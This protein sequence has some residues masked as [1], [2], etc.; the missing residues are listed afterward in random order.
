MLIDWFTVAAQAVNFLVLIWLLKRFLY[1][2]ILSAIDAR[3]KALAARQAD[4]ETKQKEA[5]AQSDDLKQKTEAF[6]QQ[7]EA[8]LQKAKAD[9]SAEQERLVADARKNADALRL[10]WQ[11][12]LRNEQHD[13]GDEMTRLAQKSVFEIA[14]KTLAELATTDIEECIT[15]VFI[16][17]LSQLSGT[18]HDQFATSLKTSSQPALV[19]SAFDLP[20]AQREAIEAAVTKAFDVPGHLHFVTA[21]DLVGGIELT[22]NGQKISWNISDLLASLGKTMDA[23]L[24]KKAAPPEEKPAPVPAPG[25]NQ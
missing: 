20:P 14:R 23:L 7:R 11:E 16:T 9:A 19:Q 18:D 4:A 25:L 21:P 3:E 17:R 13:L 2:P 8:L 5:Q 22:A 10:E 24:E 1:A 15:H 12:A 6:D